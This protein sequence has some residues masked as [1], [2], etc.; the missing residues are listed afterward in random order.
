MKPLPP[1]VNQ[2]ASFVSRRVFTDGDVYRREQQRIFARSWLYLA[3][4]SELKE[5]GDF[6]TGFLGETPVIAARGQDGAIHVSVNSCTHR[7]LPVCRAERGHAARFIC[8]YHNWTYALDGRLLA[9]PQQALTHTQIDKGALGLRRVTRVESYRGLV[10]ASL[11]DGI[12]PL[13]QYLGNMRFYLDNY[14]DRFPGGVQVIGPPHKWRIAANWKLPVENQLG[15]VGHGP[16]LHGFIMRNNSA[17]T[18]INEFGLNVV[19]EPGHGAAIRLFP[20]GTDSE[21]VMWGSENGSARMFSAETQ[22]YLREVQDQLAGRLGPVHAR[23][24]GL[25]FGVYPNFSF[26]WANSVIRVS[27]P[28]APGQVDYWSWWVVPAD[29]PPAVKCELQ[30]LYNAS[31]GPAGLF[32]QDDSEAWSQQYLG[33]AIEQ[34]DDQPYFYG[35]GLGEEQPH[36]L[37]PGKVGTSFNEHYARAFYLRW[38]RDIESAGD[39]ARPDGEAR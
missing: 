27:H 24:K 3:H 26:L 18:E 2:D 14:F 37:L 22:A 12:Q 35:L 39:D 23:I 16:F 36:P 21:T 33:S 6:V 31:F 15:D 25:T 8:P 28:R 32:E 1:L 11:D 38:K 20:E 13:D 4:E 29:A 7:G 30:S 34:L 9:V 5:K 19:P 10:F 17:T